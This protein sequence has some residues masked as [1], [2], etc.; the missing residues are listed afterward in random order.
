MKNWDD[1]RYYLTVAR[2][3]TVSAAAR[4]LHVSH[5][6][7]LRRIDALETELGVK[8]FQRLQSGYQLTEAGASLYKKVTDL[9]ADVQFLEA[10]V[11]GHDEAISGVIRVTQTEN[12]VI[13]LYPIYAEFCRQFPDIKLEVLISPENVN[14]N[15]LEADVAIRQTENPDE[16]LVGRKVGSVRFSAFAS[17]EYLARFAT[18]PSIAE[19]DWVVWDKSVSNWSIDDSCFHQLYQQVADPKVVM[20]TSNYSEILAAIKA[21]MGAGFLS[22]EIARQDANLEA[23]PHSPITAQ[24]SIWVLTH[25]DLRQLNRVR[26]FM[27]FVAEHLSNLLS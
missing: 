5:S 4:S 10:S 26:C 15:K 13:N 12:V 24:T 18:P 14:L 6:T 22:H 7:V 17:T 20:E 2:S 9:D 16:L 3:G 1:L 19:L 27:N 25:R 8:L 23:I 11:K 21:G